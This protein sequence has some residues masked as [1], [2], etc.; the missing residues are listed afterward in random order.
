MVKGISS[1]P[2]GRISIR[3]QTMLNLYNGATFDYFR[4]GISSVYQWHFNGYEREYI[5]VQERLWIKQHQQLQLLDLKT[6]RF[7]E[8][9][10]QVMTSYGFQKNLSTFL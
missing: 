7:V 4:K 2:D 9:I 1:L 6:N 8:E 5:D 3:T 10:S